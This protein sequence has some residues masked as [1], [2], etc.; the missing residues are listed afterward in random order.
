MNSQNYKDDGHPKWWD[1]STYRS[2]KDDWID[3]ADAF[4]ALHDL[5]IG[6]LEFDESLLKLMIPHIA[7]KDKRFKKF[8]VDQ[9]DQA[10]HKMHKAL[11]DTIR[12]KVQ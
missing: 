11:F 1:E 8:P 3:G 7:T 5:D 9:F 4:L 12:S 2:Y 6:D 10:K